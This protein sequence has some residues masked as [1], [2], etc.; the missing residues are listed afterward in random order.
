MKKLVIGN[1]KLNPET[2]AEA[3]ELAKSTDIS[4]VVL[5]PPD[6]F[7]IQVGEVIK[8]ASLGAQDLFWKDAAAVNG[9]ASAA[10]LKQIGVR[11]VIVGHSSRRKELKETDELINLK[12]KAALTAKLK[13]IL[14]VGEDLNIHKQGETATRTFVLQQLKK[15]LAGVNGRENLIVAYEPVWSISTSGTGLADTPEGAA[16]VIGYIKR[17]LSKIGFDKVPVL[18]GG[19]VDSKTAKGFF[20]EDIIDGVLVGKASLDVEEFKQIISLA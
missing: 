17:E 8:E 6:I 16:T 10:Q 19:S 11:Y 14:C 5:C 18:Y 20:L 13:V 12:V 9:E 15:D 3:V 7:L 2:V 4:G 1:W